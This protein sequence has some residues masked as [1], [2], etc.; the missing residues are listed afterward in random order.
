MFPWSSFDRARYRD[1][2]GS[3][4]ELRPFFRFVNVYLLAE[5]LVFIV[6]VAQMLAFMFALDNDIDRGFR[7]GLSNGLSLFH[8]N[9]PAFVVNLAQ[10]THNGNSASWWIF[11]FL[12]IGVV[13]DIK[14]I[15]SVSLR[16]LPDTV[17]WAWTWS[18][19]QASCYVALSAAAVTWFVYW[20]FVRRP[21]ALPSLTGQ[22]Q[23]LFAP[24]PG[25]G[26]NR[27]EQGL[28]VQGYAR[29]R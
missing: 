6:W 28:L 14:S 1:L 13:G 3:V 7:Y 16:R 20:F 8:Y 2:P 22:P 9:V 23:N 29:M 5:V 19:V 12:V 11:I 27:V 26:D 15:L 21:A 18:L 10:Q 25:D 17:P 4:K 24:S